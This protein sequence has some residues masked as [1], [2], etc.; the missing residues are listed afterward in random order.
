MMKKILILLIAMMS[1]TTIVFAWTEEETIQWQ[2]EQWEQASAEANKLM[3]YIGALVDTNNNPVAGVCI[4]YEVNYLNYGMARTDVTRGEVYTDAS[5]NF[6]I[7]GTGT[8]IE[9]TIKGTA[10]INY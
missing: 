6:T 10:P 7:E 5:G 3:T 2:R 9:L 8:G 1:I 4:K